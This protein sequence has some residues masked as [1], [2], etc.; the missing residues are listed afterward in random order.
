MKTGWAVRSMCPGSV[1]CAA[2][3]E[4]ALVEC[5]GHHTAGVRATGIRS[6]QGH[7]VRCNWR[8][9]GMNVC[10]GSRVCESEGVVVAG[11]VIARQ[12]RQ[13][14]TGGLVGGEGPREVG[15]QARHRGRRLPSSGGYLGWLMKRQ[16]A[17]RL[18]P[19][20]LCCALWCAAAGMPSVILRC[21]PSALV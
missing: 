5:E 17:A 10:A 18:W 13:R 14:R 12:G 9:A 7:A 21:V 1:R 3:Q 11:R 6:A 8:V 15:R 19:A 20:C 4:A 16:E 2:A